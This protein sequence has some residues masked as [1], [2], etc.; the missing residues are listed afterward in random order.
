MTFQYIAGFFDGEGH[1][2]IH[3]GKRA[4]QIT[5]TLANTHKP[6]ILAL[7]RF[8]KDEGILSR[9][10][11]RKQKNPKWKT[12]YALSIT[13]HLEQV[14]FLEGIRPFTI[15]KNEAIDRV[16]AFIKDKSWQIDFTLDQITEAL[17]LYKKGL[18]L[19]QI[20]K[21]LGISSRCLRSHALK[22][23]ITLRDQSTAIR[24]RKR[25]TN[26]ATQSS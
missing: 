15:T 20:E 17:T 7:Q 8:L 26:L 2:G 4:I 12:C 22:Q 19:R 5:V 6:T 25:G 24:L 16:L 10:Y 18:S 9:V 11:A 3:E 21:E 14:R 23:G 13:D 1:V